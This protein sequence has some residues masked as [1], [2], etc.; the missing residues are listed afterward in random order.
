MLIATGVIIITAIIL[1]T[2][3]AIADVL[4]SGLPSRYSYAWIIA[5]AFAPGVGAFLWARGR[6]NTRRVAS[7][8]PVR[9]PE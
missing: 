9:G 8:A 4:E 6:A 3:I 7:R 2:T 1:T 5:I